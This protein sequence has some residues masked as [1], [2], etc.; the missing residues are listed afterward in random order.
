MKDFLRV[1][2]VFAI[3]ASCGSLEKSMNLGDFD[4]IISKYENSDPS[5]NEPELNFQIAEAFRKSNR[6]SESGTFYK[7]AIDQGYD[8]EM[9]N[10]H[11]AHALKANQKYDESERVLRDYVKS[12]RNEQVLRMANKEL[13]NLDDVDNLTKKDNYYRVKNL[14]DI[15]TSNAEYSPVYKNNYLYFTSN[16]NGGRIYKSTGTPFTDLY[17]VRTKGANVNL[18][19]LEALDPIINNP[20]VNE[21]SLTISPDGL[22]IVFAKG[23][24]GKATGNNEVNLYYTRYRNG[25][26]LD[27]RP[28]SINEPDS[29]DSSPA[30]SA[31]GKTLYFS[32][33]R[34]GGEGGADLYSAKL[35][36]RGRWVDVRNMGPEINTP[37]NEMF[38]Y[39]SQDGSLYFSS[40]G[41]PG[42]G[43]LDLF[44]ATRRSGH[45]N[46]RNMGKP[47]NSSAD[48]FA[49]FEYNLT[50]GFLTSNRRGGAGDDDIYTFINDDPDLKVV[51]YYL[52]GTTVTTD[53][54]GEKIT[55][56]NT[57]V[58][59][60]GEDGAI[61][62]ESF[63]GEDGQFRFRV[64]PEENY[65][66]IAEKT[67]YFTVRDNFSTVGKSVDRSTLKDFITNVEFETEVPM[68]R[69]VIEKSIVLN[70]IYYD[71]DKW[72]IRPDAAKVLDSLVLILNDNPDIFIELSSH[73]DDRQTDEY[74]LDLSWKRA[75]SAV[76]YIVQEGIEAKRV[77]AKGY[78]ESKL[79]I[80]YAKTEE[81]HQRN[82]RTEFKV[83][84]YNP[85]EK[86]VNPVD[87]DDLDEYDRFFLEGDVIEEGNR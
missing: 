17:R 78:G 52:T 4:T 21:G 81:E 50:R 61:L 34:P 80:Q 6:I 32:S 9:S 7:A 49:Y 5:K 11:Y 13:S 86:D 79:L 47:M 24:T 36:P 66:L 40:D 39:V 37:G 73:T 41:H 87:P 77:T 64:Y 1:F 25:K 56:A 45:I 57:K 26:W 31:D 71:L 16:R 28:L 23:N 62:D 69:I 53:D 72:A 60:M 55:V 59:L 68:E 44:K 67:D 76:T 70:N 22:S 20:I 8:D 84:S 58:V 75:R 63:T 15:N 33:T 51:N 19:T 3:T 82:R 10:L 29:W 85:R 43:K 38:P 18:R 27:P 2:V 30:L 35:N 14:T 42:F 12:G 74:N 46:V 65:K 54:G 48:D 83:L